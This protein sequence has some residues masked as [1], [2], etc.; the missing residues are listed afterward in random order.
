[1]QAE[2]FFFYCEER[3]SKR[4]NSAVEGCAR[5][6]LYCRAKPDCAS[7]DEAINE[8]AVCLDRRP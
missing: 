1:V 7:M 2:R 8:V 6:G 4:R 3:L 5:S